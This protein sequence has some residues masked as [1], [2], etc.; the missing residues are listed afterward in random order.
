MKRQRASDIARELNNTERWH[1]HG[2]G[3]SM[4]VLR[5]DLKLLID[6][7][8]QNP[9]LNDQIRRYHTLLDDYMG[10]MGQKGVLHA[11]GIYQPFL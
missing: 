6:D 11:V 3:I 4:E 8:G 2:Y 1:T 9:T 5:R 7:F 10:K